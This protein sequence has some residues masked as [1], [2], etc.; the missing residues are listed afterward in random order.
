MFA[1]R[2]LTRRAICAGPHERSVRFDTWTSSSQSAAFVAPARGE[3][4]NAAIDIPDF[5]AELVCDAR[6]GDVAGAGII[7]TLDLV[8]AG[9][10]VA[11]VYDEET[12]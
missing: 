8:G 10:T 11:P 7:L 3:L 4:A 5:D 12:V 9:D 1:A 6:F 2:R